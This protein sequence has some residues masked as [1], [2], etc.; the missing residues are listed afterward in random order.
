M[1]T[2]SKPNTLTFYVRPNFVLKA[3]SI[4]T[5]TGLKG[6]PTNTTNTLPVFGDARTSFETSQGVG[7]AKWDSPVC[8]LGCH[9]V[10]MTGCWEH[11]PNLY[12]DIVHAYMFCEMG[13]SGTLLEMSCRV[14]AWLLGVYVHVLR[15]TKWD[16][17]VRCLVEM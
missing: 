15:K 16:R 10:C 14:Y 2:Q 4:L 12:A 9:I 8:C 11:V 5:I 17:P 3:G 1:H 6:S 13:Q 7:F